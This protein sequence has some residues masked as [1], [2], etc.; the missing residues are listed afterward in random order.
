[1]KLNETKMKAMIL[2]AGKGTRLRPYTNQIPKCMIPIAGKPILAYIIEWLGKHGIREIIINLHY[3]PEVIKSYFGEGEKWGV[4][5]FYSHEERLLGTAGGVKNVEFFFDGPFLV[6]YGDNLS[7][8][9]LIKLYQFHKAKGGLGTIVLH[10]REEV[11]QSGVVRLNGEDR[12]IYFQEKPKSEQ[13]HSNWVNAG[14]YLFEREVLNYICPDRSSDFGLDVFP[15]LLDKGERLYGY[16]LSPD[17][18]FWWIDR[19]ED[20][21]KVLDEWRENK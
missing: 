16:R 20:L 8:C 3:L 2:A 14:I 9:N 12:I 4:K 11:N 6:W 7:T 10:R 18:G 13:P 19:P 1:M 5:I 21:E 17:E 15:R